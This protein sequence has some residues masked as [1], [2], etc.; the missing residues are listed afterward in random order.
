VSRGFS[1]QHL[2]LRLRQILAT[3]KLICPQ[4]PRGATIRPS[5]T[6]LSQRIHELYTEVVP[7]KLNAIAIIGNS[8]SAPSQKTIDIIHLICLL[9]LCI[10]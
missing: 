5:I 1:L 3:L 8:S 2:A 10:I 7:R 4:S 6:A 9:F